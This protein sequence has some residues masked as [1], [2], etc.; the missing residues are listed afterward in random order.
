MSTIYQPVMAEPQSSSG[1]WIIV[2]II[3][4]LVIIGLAIWLIVRYTQDKNEVKEMAIPVKSVTAGNTNVTVN[5]GALDNED[6]KV[7]VC[8]SMVPSGD[9]STSFV[10]TIPVFCQSDTGSNKGVTINNLTPQKTYFITV[11]VL[12][13]NKN[14]SYVPYTTTVWTQSK[15]AVRGQTFNIQNLNQKTGVSTAAAY[16]ANT[17]EYGEYWQTS[18]FLLRRR[19]ADDDFTDLGESYNILCRVDNKLTLAQKNDSEEGAPITI[20][21]PVSSLYPD[22][23]RQIPMSD[24]QWVYNNIESGDATQT[25][26]W[27]LAFQTLNAGLVCMHSNTGSS[28]ISVSTSH[29]DTDVWA[30]SY[31]SLVHPTAYNNNNVQYNCN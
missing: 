15:N 13:K 8:A 3:L 19:E 31:V 14:V 16:S 28:I 29:T 30:N 17:T 1:A 5:W 10:S 21:V 25:N 27:C 4:I 2:I 26:K 18:D 20:K 9:L 7:T 11:R 23:T 6:D 12:S 22:G 24:C